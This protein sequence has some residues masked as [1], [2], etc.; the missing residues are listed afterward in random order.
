[1]LLL[2]NNWSLRIHTDSKDNLARIQITQSLSV[3]QGPSRVRYYYVIL[4]KLLGKVLLLH[5]KSLAHTAGQTVD[6]I[7]HLTF[8]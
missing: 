8:E 4:N 2:Q 5:D 1:M 6:T 7:T 3:L